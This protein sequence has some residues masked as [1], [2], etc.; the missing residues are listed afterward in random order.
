MSRQTA[1]ILLKELDGVASHAIQGDVI[2]QLV[3]LGLDWRMMA[4]AVRRYPITAG[5]LYQFLGWFLA[6]PIPAP[7]GMLSVLFGKLCENGEDAL[8]LGI[9]VQREVTRAQ[10]AGG[11]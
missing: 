8:S 3:Y 7:S 2:D 1:A 11:G 6:E 4:Y 9:A 5:K 10:R